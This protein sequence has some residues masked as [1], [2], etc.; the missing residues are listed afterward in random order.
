MWVELQSAMQHH[1]I[2]V[3]FREIY[4][5]QAAQYDLLVAREDYQ[6]RIL[7]AL[8]AIRPLVGLQVIELGA[9]T[10]RL[11]RLLAPLV[12]HIL[13]L[14]ISAH[15]LNTAQA[16]M[17][18]ARRSW[19]VTVADNR[20][21]PAANGTADLAI[22]GWTLGHLVGW[23]TKDWP[24]QIG[25]AVSEM[26]RVLKPGGTAVILETLGTGRESPAPPTSSLADYYAYLEQEH[27]FHLTWIRTDYRFESLA[28]AESLIRFFFGQKLAE[29]VV[30][31]KLLILPECT[32]IWWVSV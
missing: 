6:G 4:N 7:P 28:E 13:A 9:G 19:S 5:Q 21:L 18:G 20:C 16:R 25:L 15:M 12:K 29:R 10:G 27:G 22:A 17:V 11:T 23:Y 26:K 32:G 31:E 24:R 2:M 1:H 8:H 14:D 30:R 3:D